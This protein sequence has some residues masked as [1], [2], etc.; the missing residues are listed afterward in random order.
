MCKNKNSSRVCSVATQLVHSQDWSR[1]KFAWCC[2]NAP[3]T[4]RLQ[5]PAIPLDPLLP[6]HVRPLM[7]SAVVLKN[8]LFI[9]DVPHSPPCNLPTLILP[10]EAA[11]RLQPR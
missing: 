9:T 11:Q 5:A 1:E 10:L 8:T 3:L 6:P 4:G 7:T 2:Q